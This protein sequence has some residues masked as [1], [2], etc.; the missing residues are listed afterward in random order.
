MKKS[1]LVIGSLIFFIGCADK[2][3]M[4]T[5]VVELMGNKE[6]VGWEGANSATTN[7]ANKYFSPSK[8]RIPVDSDSDGVPDYSDRCP[9][10]PL[11][12]SVNH[13]GC[14]LITTLRLNFDYKSTKVK[15]E[16]MKKIKKL[17]EYLKTH[18]NVRIEIDGYT[19]DT[20]SQ[21]YNLALSRKRAEAVRDILV[22]QYHINPSRI[23]VKAFGEKYPIVP[24]TTPQNKALNRRVEIVAIGKDSK[25]L[26]TNLIIN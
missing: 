13:Y 23:V 12:V 5:S 9:N 3:K 17:A 14:K 21:A 25:F 18:K 16:Y 8:K 7:N 26:N 22:K 4:A 20:G 11:G 10:T 2:T 19:D 1:F 6:V 15:K 24:N